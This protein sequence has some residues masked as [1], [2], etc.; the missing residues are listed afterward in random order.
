MNKSG[1][2]QGDDLYLNGGKGLYKISNRLGLS[3][4]AVAYLCKARANFTHHKVDEMV[5]H[6]TCKTHFLE[7][8]N[9]LKIKT[10]C[11]ELLPPPR[12]GVKI[13][14]TPKCVTF[15]DPT[16]DLKP[17][18]WLSTES[19]GTE[20]RQGLF[21]GRENKGEFRIGFEISKDFKFW[22]DFA[23]E[24]SADPRWRK[25]LEKGHRHESWVVH[26]GK[27]NLRKV[28]VALHRRVN[29]QWVDLIR[30]PEA[31]E[32]PAIKGMPQKKQAPFLRE[33]AD[34]TPSEAEPT[35]EG[36]K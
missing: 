33:E 21:G 13:K 25:Y 31:I 14:V 1:V 34:T 17:V 3:P 8:L 9:S 2:L 10:T 11:S 29:G 35:N 24:N 15:W 32:P 30:H 28:E 27:I 5:F 19:N 20:W 26:E 4:S 16:Y 12:E 22:S 7:I 6:Y 36:E 18:V 23:E